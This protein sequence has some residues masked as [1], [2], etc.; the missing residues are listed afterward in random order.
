MFRWLVLDRPVRLRAIGLW[1][2]DLASSSHV[3]WNDF[4]ADL[5]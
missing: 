5:C 3:E 2:F 4:I 1:P